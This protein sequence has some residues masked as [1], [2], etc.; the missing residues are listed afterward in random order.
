VDA[1]VEVWSGRFQDLARDAT[2]SGD[3]ELESFI[4]RCKAAYDDGN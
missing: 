1:P 3:Q 2:A 4:Q